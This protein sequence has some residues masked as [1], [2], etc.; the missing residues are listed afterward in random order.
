MTPEMI[1]K[2]RDNA[3]KGHYENVE[4]RL[5]DIENLPVPDDSVDIIIS[6]CVINLTVD[7]KKAFMEAY[8]VLKP[9]GR[10]MV[11]DIVLS[12]KLPDFIKHSIEAYVGCVAGAMI[13]EEYLGAIKAAGFQEV[14]IIDESS[15]PVD[16]MAN[17]PTVQ[18]IIENSKLHRE[19]LREVASSVKSARIYA[20]KPGARA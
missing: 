4:F 6:N 15:L 18:T 10:L 3:Q 19:K 5:G 13:R 17:D 14:R 2:A 7:K 9:G 8:R 20:V 11:S 16:D 1:Q 12:K